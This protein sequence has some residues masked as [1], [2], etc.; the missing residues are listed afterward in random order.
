MHGIDAWASPGMLVQKAMQQAALITSV[1]RFTRS[2]MLGNWLDTEPWRV[3]VPP[4]TVGEAFTPGPVPA[5]LRQRY[6]IGN[7]RV[8]LTISR[9]SAAD[10]YKGHDRVIAALP[11]V[12]RRGADVTYLVA[13]DGDGL[14]RLK[15]LVAEAG[16]A[17]RVQFIGRI[18]D[19]EL[20]D[21]YRLADVFIMPS[22]GKASASCSWR[23]RPAARRS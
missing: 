16:L 5:G 3:P 17:D 15:Q 8:I 4:N 11:E 23:R 18:A 13:G 14:P 7:R 21:H 10:S 12:I 22:T 6:R 9:I 1:S 19:A 2:Q 20:V